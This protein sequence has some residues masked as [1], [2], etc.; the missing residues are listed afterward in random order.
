VCNQELGVC[1]DAPGQL[2]P[3]GGGG[4]TRVRR[5]P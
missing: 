2:C 1:E 5:L 3:S 4:F